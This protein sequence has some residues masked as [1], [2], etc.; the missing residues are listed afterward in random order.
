MTRARVFFLSES[1]RYNLESASHWGDP[2]FLFDE[3]PNPFLT[4]ELMRDVLD[5][6]CHHGYKPERDFFALTG[7]HR[8]VSLALAA[9]CENHSKVGILMF[10]STGKDYV[11]RFLEQKG[12]IATSRS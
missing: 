5:R 8:S 12:C 6:L 4:F 7:D 11:P 1:K 9:I 10:E 3:K 2:V